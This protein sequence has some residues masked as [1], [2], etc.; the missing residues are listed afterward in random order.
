MLLLRLR[1]APAAVTVLLLLVRQLA[2][3]RPDEAEVMVLAKLAKN[4]LVPLLL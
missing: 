3:T 2:E 1:G 4:R